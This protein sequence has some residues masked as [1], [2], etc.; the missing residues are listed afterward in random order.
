MK[1]VTVENTD[2]DLLY[3]RPAGDT[4]QGDLWQSGIKEFNLVV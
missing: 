3:S 1:L 2:Y 4:T